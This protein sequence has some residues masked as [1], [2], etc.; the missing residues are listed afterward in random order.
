MHKY[1]Q[2]VFLSPQNSSFEWI[3]MMG[4][5]IWVRCT[6]FIWTLAEEKCVERSC[7]LFSLVVP[8]LLCG[9]SF[10]MN[11]Y[12]VLSAI[13]C[14]DSYIRFFFKE[15]KWL[16]VCTLYQRTLP[17]NLK[18]IGNVHISFGWSWMKKS[19]KRKRKKVDEPN[20]L[21]MNQLHVIFMKW[22][23]KFNNHCRT[24]LR[25]SVFL[26]IKF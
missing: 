4:I 9:S 10:S 26:F 20:S 7:A 19:V 11:H 15:M 5:V 1:I 23:G 17:V 3:M 2:L 8:I 12:L 14:G 25:L 13:N 22:R 24:E 21:E 6:H 18:E 16:F